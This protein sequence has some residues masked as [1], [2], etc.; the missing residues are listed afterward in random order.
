MCV[1]FRCVFVVSVG[2]RWCLVAGVWCLVVCCSCLV[3]C[4]WR[5]VRGV[6]LCVHLVCGVE[7][8][9]GDW[10]VVDR[11]LAFSFLFWWFARGFGIVCV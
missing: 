5:L 9:F 2:G 6:R 1:V 10:L 4:G 11:S 3:S 7:F 8:V